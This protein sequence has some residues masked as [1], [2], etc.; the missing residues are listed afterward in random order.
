[1]AKSNF[2]DLSINCLTQLIISQPRIYLVGDSPSIK[3]LSFLE[4][5]IQ[6]CR[7][8]PGFRSV[9]FTLHTKDVLSTV[10]NVLRSCSLPVEHMKG[11]KASPQTAKSPPE[12]GVPFY[13]P[14]KWDKTYYT[15]TGFRDP[16]Q[17]LQQAQRVEP[18][19]RLVASSPAHISFTL[20]SNLQIF[21]G[22]CFLLC[23]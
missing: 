17:E 13:R 19:L 10:V 1:M 6:V 4:K 16:E 20:E 2:T 22:L 11:L 9:S 5:R 3:R 14:I 23:H 8:F 12:A 18:T 15:F 21:M 7:H